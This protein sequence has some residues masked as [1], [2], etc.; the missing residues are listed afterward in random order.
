MS[1][2][3]IGIDLGVK[4]KHYAEIRNEEGKRVRPSFSFSNSKDSFDALCKHALKDT[5]K[6][7]K[8]RFI[9]EPT[10]MSWFP[11][12]VYAISHVHQM[13]GVKAQKAHDLREYYS[14]HR[15]RDGIDAKVLSLI[16]IV[17]NDSLEEVHLPNKSIYAL[18]RHC[19]QREKTTK[20]IARTKAR[21]K[22]LYH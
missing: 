9:C 20:D 1:V 4:S 15:K 6:G 11:L 17:D 5:P 10:A 3:N 14:K 7:T 2:L 8:L 22:S 19:R 13:V 21:L 16:P 18:D 12:T